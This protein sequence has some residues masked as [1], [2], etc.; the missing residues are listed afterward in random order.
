MRQRIV[1]V[2]GGFAGLWAVWRKQKQPLTSCTIVTTTPTPLVAPIHDR[3]PVILEPEDYARWLDVRENPV[4]T[5]GE[6]LRPARD[7]L[8]EAIAV[9][10]RVNKADNDDPAL[11]EPV[12]PTLF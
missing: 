9:G 1:V 5:V 12:E 10:T 6:L 3:M 11:L 7:D 4:D 8:L 2:G